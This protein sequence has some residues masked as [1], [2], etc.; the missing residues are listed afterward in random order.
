MDEPHY[1]KADFRVRVQHLSN[2]LPWQLGLII[3]QAW[4]ERSLHIYIRVQ[5]R[6]SYSPYASL[7]ANLIL[8]EGGCILRLCLPLSGRTLSFWVTW[9]CRATHNMQRYCKASR[10]IHIPRN[11][12]F[13]AADNFIRLLQRSETGNNARCREFPTGSES[14]FQ[15]SMLCG[16]WPVLEA[17]IIFWWHRG[18]HVLCSVT[19]HLVVNHDSDVGFE[20]SV[21]CCI[22]LGENPN[23]IRLD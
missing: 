4:W 7:E 3:E 17:H 23:N 11:M 15:L 12:K 18:C 22:P 2:T 21:V 10:S 9:A 6:H 5:S 13:G 19:V 14:F 1:A 8:W 20:G 16:W